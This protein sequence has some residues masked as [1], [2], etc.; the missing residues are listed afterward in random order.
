MCLKANLLMNCVADMYEHEGEEGLRRMADQ[1]IQL[2]E[3]TT[4]PG[5]YLVRAQSGSGACPPA[6]L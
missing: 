2:L 5:Q 3:R 4:Q 1:D 6:T